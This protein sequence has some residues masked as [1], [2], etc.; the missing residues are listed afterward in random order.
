MQLKLNILIKS[1][2]DITSGEL[3]LSGIIQT[4]VLRVK[5][6][7]TKRFEK[8]WVVPLHSALL[9]LSCRGRGLLLF[10]HRPDPGYNN[11]FVNMC[12]FYN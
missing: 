1:T 3:C 12:L 10:A 9:G 6:K 7:T 5:K 4:Q 11:Y 8:R 2:I